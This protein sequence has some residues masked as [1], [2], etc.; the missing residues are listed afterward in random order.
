MNFPRECT[1]ASGK[2]IYLKANSKVTIQLIQELLFAD[3]AAL[4]THSEEDLQEMVTIFSDAAKNVE[5][6]VRIRK[7]EI[8]LQPAP[9]DANSDPHI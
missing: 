5:L 1:F 6:Y 4:V 8:L 3:D 7:T 2:D 9:G